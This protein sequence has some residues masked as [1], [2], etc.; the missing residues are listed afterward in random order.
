[1]AEDLADR[2]DDLICSFEGAVGGSLPDL[3][4][5][6]LAALAWAAVGA[7]VV[8]IA[9]ILLRSGRS[10]DEDAAQQRSGERDLA[11]RSEEIIG[12]KIAQLKKESLAEAANA[13][14]PVVKNGGGVSR[15]ATTGV[16]PKVEVVESTPVKRKSPFSTPPPQPQPPSCPIPTSLGSDDEAVAWVNASLSALCCSSRARSKVATRWREAVQEY[17]RASAQEVGSSILV[18]R[19][20]PHAH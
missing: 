5:L 10:G 7:I 18:H 3:G 11:K 4:T 14:P 2:L 9:A 17:A 15:S 6:L 1:M 19:R 16:V 13:T 20:K 8:G 12:K